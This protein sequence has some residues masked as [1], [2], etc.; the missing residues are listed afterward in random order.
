MILSVR[1]SVWPSHSPALSKRLNISSNSFRLL[2]LA[3][4]RFYC[5]KHQSEI[6]TEW[7]LNVALNIRLYL[8]H[9]CV[10]SNSYVIYCQCRHFIWRHC[11]WPWVPL[12][13]QL[14]QTFLWSVTCKRVKALSSYLER[15]P[16]SAMINIYSACLFD[17]MWNVIRQEMV[18]KIKI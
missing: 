11:R 4:F 3:S 13:L 10:N 1:L 7:P 6:R 14:L 2:I 12:S 16:L 15:I 17:L 9:S 18:V 8:R 5:V